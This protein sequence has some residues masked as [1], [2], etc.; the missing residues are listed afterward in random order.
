MRGMRLRD[1]LERC[2]FLFLSPLLVGFLPNPTVAGP[3]ADGYLLLHTDDSVVYTS[4]DTS[5]FCDLY[6]PECPSDPDCTGDHLDCAGALLN[7]DP[8]SNRGTAVSVFWAIAAFPPSSCPRVLAVQFGL[9]WPANQTPI[10]VGHG[11]CGVFEVASEGWPDELGAGTAVA[12]GE[13]VSRT[14]FP[15]YWFAAYCYY[16][17]QA[18]IQVSDFPVGSDGAAFADDSVP[19]I[20][21]EIPSQNRGSIGLNGAIGDNPYWIPSPVGACC[22]PSGDCVLETAGDC[23]TDGGTYLGD[24]TACNPNPCNPTPTLSTTWGGVKRSFRE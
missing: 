13:P 16:G 2:P 3:N 20:L 22:L 11:K 1:L 15:V 19:S 5:A 14:G 7:L 23:E 24:G 12:F 17:S 6:G 18:L 4:D 9:A 10:F 8:T 21:D